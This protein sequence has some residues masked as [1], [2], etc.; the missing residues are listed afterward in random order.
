MLSFNPKGGQQ[1][2]VLKKKAKILYF[3]TIIYFNS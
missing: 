2:L 3:F 1:M